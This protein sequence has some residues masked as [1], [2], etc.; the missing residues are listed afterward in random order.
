[1]IH[2]VEHRAIVKAKKQIAIEFEKIVNE[3]LSDDSK[4]VFCFC[5]ECKTGFSVPRFNLKKV[6]CCPFCCTENQNIFKA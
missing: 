3:L 2:L 4:W 6:V 5:K 1:M